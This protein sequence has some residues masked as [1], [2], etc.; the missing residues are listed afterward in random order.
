[1]K[2]WES[3]KLFSLARVCSLVPITGGKKSS[4]RYVVQITAKFFASSLRGH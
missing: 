2:K 3:L 4:L 1:M